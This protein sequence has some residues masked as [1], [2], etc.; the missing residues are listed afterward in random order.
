LVFFIVLGICVIISI[1]FWN[2]G[3]FKRKYMEPI[4]IGVALLGLF[5]LFQPFSFFLYSHGLGI[6][7]PGFIGFNIALHIK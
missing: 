5:C 7:L 6:F 2:M 1:V 3:K 4:F